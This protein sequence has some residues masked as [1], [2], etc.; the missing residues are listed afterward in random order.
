MSEELATQAWFVRI[1]ASET[2]PA[3]I[4]FAVGAATPQDAIAAVLNHPQL[5][6]GDEVASI[7]RLSAEMR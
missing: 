6:F 1:K 7:S 2:T 3:V 4:D 5:D